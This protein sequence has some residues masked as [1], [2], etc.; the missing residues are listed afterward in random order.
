MADKNKRLSFTNKKGEHVELSPELLEKA[1]ALKLEFQ[2][3][4]GSCSWGKL[5]KILRDEG[6]SGID[7]SEN[8][9]VAVRRYQKKIGKLPTQE[10]RTDLQ[11]KALKERIGELNLQKRDLQNT[12]REFNK[13]KRVIDDKFLWEQR[14]YESVPKVLNPEQ[15]KR[16]SK[17]VSSEKGDTLIVCLSDLHIGLKTATYDYATLKNNISQYL[18][19]IDK[20]IKFKQIKQIFV[21]GLG[22]FIEGAYLHTTQLYELEFDFST[23]VGKMLNLILGFLSSLPKDIPVSFTAIPGNHDRSNAPNKKDNLFGDSVITILNMLVKNQDKV[24]GINYINPTT[25]ARHLIKVNGVNIVCVHGDLDHLKDN[26]VISK[27][28][29]FFNERVD[30]VVGGHLHSFYMRTL[31]K[32]QYIIQ[33][34]SAF[35]GNSYSDS[36]GV[37]NTPGQV[38]LDI[39]KDGLVIPI[40]VPFLD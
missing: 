15:F 21:I 16:D 11:I 40:F 27:L 28:S 26:G 6:Y 33:S 38:M 20:Y 37:K 3:V 9:R 14:L 18:D 29:A 24:L 13:L 8:F 5:A 32:N 10:H 12:K 1:V 34:S 36:L 31:G 35:P 39:N 22:D 7:N 23:Q 30:V 4:N 25:V 2:R 19:Y 17:A